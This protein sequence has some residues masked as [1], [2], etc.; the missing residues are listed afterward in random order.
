M[1]SACAAL[2]ARGW[3]MRSKC[4]LRSLEV[5]SPRLK[6]CIF[7]CGDCDDF[8]A[9]KSCAACDE[10]KIDTGSSKSISARCAVGGWG[11]ARRDT[12]YKLTII[13]C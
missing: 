3:T 5:G 13:R 11:G 7:A 2:A 10:T 6:S 9:L 12:Q 8:A 1:S 4:V